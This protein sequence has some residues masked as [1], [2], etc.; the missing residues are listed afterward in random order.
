MKLKCRVQA[1]LVVAWKAEDSGDWVFTLCRRGLQEV[2]GVP[3]RPG[4][5]V[6]FDLSGKLIEQNKGNDDGI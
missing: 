1:H 3:L 2:L 6:T 5:E 4:D